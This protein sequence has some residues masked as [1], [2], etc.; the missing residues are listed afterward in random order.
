MSKLNPIIPRNQ[1]VKF[2]TK[3]P[4]L[5]FRDKQVG[6][7]PPYLTPAANGPAM[8]RLHPSEVP[9]G[10]SA[11]YPPAVPPRRHS[12]PQPTHYQAPAYPPVIYPLPQGQSQPT[13]SMPGISGNQSGHPYRP[14]VSGH[15]PIPSFMANQHQQVPQ[16]SRPSPQRREQVL[17][18]QKRE[19]VLVHE[20]KLTNQDIP[21]MERRVNAIRQERVAS[22]KFFSSDQKTFSWPAGLDPE[23]FAPKDVFKVT[24]RKGDI[25]QP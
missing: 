10:P 16:S 13:P 1:Y 25:F 3:G 8:G 4:L 21:D 23:V 14:S 2:S 11:M 18:D 17:A 20:F 24:P 22:G 19:Q 15:D 7:H 5:V 6:G 12:M 9:Q